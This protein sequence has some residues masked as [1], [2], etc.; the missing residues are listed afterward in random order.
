MFGLRG[1]FEY[2]RMRAKRSPVDHSIA[3][4]SRMPAHHGVLAPLTDKAGFLP[5]MRAAM[6]VMD[7]ERREGKARAQ[8]GQIEHAIEVNPL[9]A[10]VAP[11]LTAKGFG[12]AA[13]EDFFFEEA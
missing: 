12:D 10:I 11:G 13:R 5:I 1:W 7:H 2:G 4:I 9:A 8:G 3:R 6:L